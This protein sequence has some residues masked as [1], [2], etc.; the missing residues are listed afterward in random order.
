M[1]DTDF[2]AAPFELSSTTDESLTLNVRDRDIS[3]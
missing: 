3:V 1:I 2:I